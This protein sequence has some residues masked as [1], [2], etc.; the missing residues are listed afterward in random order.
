MGTYLFVDRPMIDLT[1][2]IAI[3]YQPTRALFPDIYHI[4]TTFTSTMSP[5]S[6]L[7]HL[8]LR[9]LRRKIH[10]VFGLK[11]RLLVPRSKPYH[12]FFTRHTIAW[13]SFTLSEVQ[14]SITFFHNIQAV[15]TDALSQRCHSSI[16]QKIRPCTMYVGGFIGASYCPSPHIVIQKY[17]VTN[18][19][20]D[21]AI[22]VRWRNIKASDKGTLRRNHKVRLLYRLLRRYSEKCLSRN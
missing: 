10:I 22:T 3:F 17:A 19:C 5:R 4:V 6:F 7:A 1:F 2:P 16:K 12:R 13:K 21:W 15:R 18:S 11:L 14:A 8:I 9:Y 20:I